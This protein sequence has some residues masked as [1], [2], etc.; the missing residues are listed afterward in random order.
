MVINF[1]EGEGEQLGR[2][3]VP[4]AIRS[5]TSRGPLEESGGDA[6][7]QVRTNVKL[8]GVDSSAV[9]GQVEPGFSGKDG[10]YQTSS[11]RRAGAVRT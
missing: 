4:A 3:E 1:R 5:N 11:G 8:A 2:L 10:E 6:G 9:P 7:T